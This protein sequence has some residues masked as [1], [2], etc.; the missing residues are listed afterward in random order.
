MGTAEKADGHPR[1]AAIPPELPSQNR[2]FTARLQ[3]PL[4]CPHAGDQPL[5]H[6]RALHRPRQR[7]RRWGHSLTAR[8]SRGT[9]PRHQKRDRSC[10]TSAISTQK[11]CSVTTLRPSPSTLPQPRSRH[12][13]PSRLGTALGKSSPEQ[14]LAVLGRIAPWVGAPR[15]FAGHPECF[16]SNIS[17]SLSCE[18]TTNAAGLPR[19][20]LRELSSSIHKAPLKRLEAFPRQASRTYSR[21]GFLPSK[22]NNSPLTSQT[23]SHAAGQQQLTL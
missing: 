18:Q 6:Q 5:Q 22:E 2:D 17:G 11:P 19:E 8:A 20:E 21:A 9:R 10:P 4:C 14:G 7:E 15:P 13:L 1:T 16:S 3:L 12:S 23:R